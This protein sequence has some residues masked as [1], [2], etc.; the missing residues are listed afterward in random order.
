[1]EGISNITP[2]ILL[3]GTGTR[4][5][6]LSTSGFP[7]QYLPLLKDNSESLF[8][9][10]LKRIRNIENIVS[11]I[12]ICNEEHRFIASEQLRQIGIT[13]KATLLEPFGRNTAPAVT[14]AAL[15]A[16]EHNKDSL[17]LVLPADHNIKNTSQF[18]K[19]IK[20]GA[21]YAKKGRITIFGVTP[22][23]PETGYGYIQTSEK[24]DPKHL[25]GLE[26]LKFIEKPSKKN[27]NEFLNSKN[28]SWNSG[29][30]IFKSSVFLK[31]VEKLNPKLLYYCKKSISKNEKDLDFERID[32]DFF[33]K[34]PNISIDVAI[35]EKTRLGT[36]I[37]L[38]AGWSD[39]GSWNSLW[40]NEEKDING[41]VLSENVW[42]KKVKDSYLR[43][44]NRLLVGI[45][46][47]DLIIVETN[48]TLLVA[49][50]SHS[51]EIKNVVED[52]LKDNSSKDELNKKSYRPWGEFISVVEGDKWKVKRIEVKPKSSLSLQKHRHR[53]EHWIVVN[54]TAKVEVNDKVLTLRENQSTYIPLG[55][56][57]RL[58]NPE[59]EPL[60]LIEV[61]SGDYLGEDDIVRFDDLYGRIS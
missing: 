44:E 36:V 6:P 7:K 18:E 38:N 16:L 10:T 29:M 42:I 14:I 21:E 58:S 4:L 57:H 43:S 39:I 5:W 61:Q 15:K 2:I 33:Q 3:G 24:I 56:K 28:F 23:S 34:C 19:V 30:F 27:A 55:A 1:M 48:N 51:Q 8:Q 50:K 45:G 52:L 46:L 26:I 40:E 13:P 17:M 59:N 9:N 41:N 47:K 12:I 20:K 31:E 25:T 37:P 60:I 49:E 35:M 22:T 32:P 54:G 53:A 11:P